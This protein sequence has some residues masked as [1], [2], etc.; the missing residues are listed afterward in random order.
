M[1]RKLR[2]E[3]INTGTQFCQ[4]CD[5][6]HILVEHHIEGRK[7]P[8]PN[9]HS[10]LSYICD[11]CHRKVHKGIIIIEG[12]FM[13]TSGLELIWHFNDEESFTNSDKE[14]YTY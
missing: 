11:N 1:N 13:T 14:T 10:N 8:N 12:Y 4:I 9:H 2:K 7:I 5:E 3:L 6:Q